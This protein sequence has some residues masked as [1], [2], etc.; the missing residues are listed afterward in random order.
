MLIFVE[1][2]GRGGL[3]R[4]ISR[5]ALLVGLASVLG[6][7]CPASAAD[8]SSKMPVGVVNSLF[9]D[10]P[11]DTVNSSMEPFVALMEK[12]TGYRGE[13]TFA[14]DAFDLGEQLTKDHVQL[15]VFHGFEFAWATQKYPEIKPL[16]I[17]VN[18]QRYLVAHLIVR[19]DNPVTDLAGLKGKSLAIPAG[20]KEHCRL[21]LERQ[22]KAI[23]VEPGRLFAK[24]TKPANIE[25][26]LDD[27]VDGLVTAALIDDV[28]LKR[29]QARKPGRSARLKDLQKSVPFPATVVAYHPG[30]LDEAALRSI[31][32]ALKKAPDTPEGRQMLTLWKLTGFED[33][34]KD[35][36]KDLADI[37]K[38][39]PP[40]KNHAQASS[41]NGGK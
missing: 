20:T 31:R 17:A 12:E 7:P 14:K 29:Y 23:G 1:R 19:N 15:G 3:R 36:D 32:A 10:T 28:G 11:K 37:L 21:F 33:V 38:T 16:G 18:Q 9:R 26:A 34:P 13:I 22:C 8:S 40:P 35:Y 25:D 24:T 30:I 41:P 5:L 2:F 27:L 39:Y 6:E 4:R